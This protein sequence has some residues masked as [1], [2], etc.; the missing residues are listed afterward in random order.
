MKTFATSSELLG[1]PEGSYLGK[2]SWR[3]VDRQLIDDFETSVA[4]G[5]LAGTSPDFAW[6]A[7]KDPTPHLG[8]ALIPSLLSEVYRVSTKRR[9]VNYGVESV[10]FFEP[11]SA[12]CHVRVVADLIRVHAVA[13]AT[14]RVHLRCTVEIRGAGPACRADTITQIYD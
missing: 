10:R 2:S 3:H 14:V 7:A 5:R 4:V 9:S 13:P 11:L 12:E 6:S 8:L 1:F